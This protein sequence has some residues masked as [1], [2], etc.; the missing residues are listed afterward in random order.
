METRKD[1]KAFL[2]H[3][4]QLSR[5]N[6]TIDDDSNGRHTKYERGTSFTPIRLVYCM[7]QKKWA[8]T[9][10]NQNTCIF[11]TEFINPD[12]TL[13]KAVEMA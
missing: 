6:L 9:T 2:Q 1:E 3:S 13:V 4:A 5:D 10:W 7:K 11:L 8:I 12:M